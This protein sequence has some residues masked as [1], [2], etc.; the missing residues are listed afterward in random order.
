MDSTTI[1]TATAALAPPFI[2]QFF[3]SAGILLGILTI[4]VALGILSGEPIMAHDP[5]SPPGY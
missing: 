4:A 3:P 2:Y 1:A 5:D